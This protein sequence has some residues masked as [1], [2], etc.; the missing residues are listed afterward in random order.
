MKKSRAA[1]PSS[2]AAS[3]I[4]RLRREN[5]ELREWRRRLSLLLEYG[6]KISVKKELDSL[7]HLLVEES[8]R[9]LRADRS[10]VF[11]LDKQANE[12]WARVASGDALIR[13]PAN[14]GIVG[15]A[16]STGNVIIIPDAYAD[17]RFNPQQDRSPGYRTRTLLTAVAACSAKMR[18]I[19]ASS[20]SKFPRVLFN[21]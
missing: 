14:K 3:L 4:E 8:K 21:T 17:R 2:R 15:E 18:R 10:T 19:S 12:L 9:V 1:A 13:V 5:R 7:L 11:L 6:K 20:A 16:V